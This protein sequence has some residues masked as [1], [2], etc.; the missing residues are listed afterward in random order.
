MCFHRG[1]SEDNSLSKSLSCFF[2]LPPSDFH[3]W[4][5]VTVYTCVGFWAHQ[6]RDIKHFLYKPHFDNLFS[7]SFS[8]RLHNDVR[9]YKLEV[10]IA[11]CTDRIRQTGKPL[12]RP[13]RSK[14]HAC[15]FYISEVF[16]FN[17]WCW[18]GF[19]LQNS[20][21]IRKGILDRCSIC[22]VLENVIRVY[23]KLSSNGSLMQQL[24]CIILSV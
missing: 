23:L 18:S 21:K 2:S 1:N 24:M 9:G 14:K 22:I 3:T 15:L 11:S 16:A 4:A 10:D 19:K 7:F 17:L 5:E 8:H 12:A 20:C 6:S 13:H